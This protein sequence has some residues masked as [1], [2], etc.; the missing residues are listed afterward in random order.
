MI[1]PSRLLTFSVSAGDYLDVLRIFDERFASLDKDSASR[2][3]ACAHFGWSGSLILTIS[4]VGIYSPRLDQSRRKCEEE[5][6][7]DRC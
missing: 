3:E 5:E 2:G 1:L 6:W 4:V 7:K